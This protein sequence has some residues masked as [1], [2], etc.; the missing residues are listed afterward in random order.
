MVGLLVEMVETVETV[1]DTVDD[2]E[3]AMDLQLE[4]VNKSNAFIYIR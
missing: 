1:G 4:L 2:M 3:E